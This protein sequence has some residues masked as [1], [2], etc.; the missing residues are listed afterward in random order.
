MT[1]EEIL[2]QVYVIIEK[3]LP[4]LLPFMAFVLTTKYTKTHEGFCLQS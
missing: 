4:A 2:T 3:I 1:F